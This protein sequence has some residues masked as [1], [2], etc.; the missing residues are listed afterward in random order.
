MPAASHNSNGK[1]HGHALRNA[2]LCEKSLQ[3]AQE[4]PPLAAAI[5]RIRV[6]HLHLTRL[7]L[8]R[9]SGISRGTLRDLE[10][11]VHT[12]TRRILKRFMSYCEGKGVPRERLEELHRLYAGEGDSLGELIAR[13]ELRAGSP[14]ELS[15]RV[16]ISPATLWEY[17]RGNFPLPLPLLQKLCRAVGE[18]PERAES[19][20]YEA[21][22][23]RLCERGYPEP[24]AEFW[25]LCARAGW[26]ENHLLRRGLNTATARKL[27]YLELPRWDEVEEVARRLCRDGREL[28]ALKRLWPRNTNG[29]AEHADSFGPRLKQLRKQQGITR[30]ELADLFVIGGK[31]PARIIKYVEEDGFYSAQAHPAGLAA[32]VARNPREQDQLLKDWQARRAQFQRRHRPEMRLDLRLRR[33]LFGFSLK[34]MEP[35]LGYTRTE[36]QRIERGVVPLRESAE[37]RICAAIDQAGQRRLDELLERRQQGLEQ[38]SAWKNPTS[39]DDMFQLLGRREGGLIPLARL[40][41]KAG[42]KGLWPGRLRALASGQEVPPWHL[43]K[44]VAESC[45]VDDLTQVQLDWVDRYRNQLQKPPRSPL[46]VELRLLIAETAPTLR[47]FSARLHFNYSVL[48]RDL[49]R[50][51]RDEEVRWFHIERILRAASVPADDER[52][53]DIRA[54]WYTARERSR[55]PAL[56]GKRHAPSTNGTG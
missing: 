21:E 27:R 56:H 48:V 47:A 6:E 7:E 10:L 22:R 32:L 49:Q 44:A 12:P 2:H 51:D 31:K 38:R 18:D 33:E 4:A 20:W 23:A 8:A 40:L 11:G 37:R 36:Y 35:I 25:V 3:R 26:S 54:L 50:I 41:R 53:R 45:Q 52:W 5:V 9:R 29:Q 46:G 16:G 19:I 17:R 43:V 14:R 42:L 55:K 28:A 39:L 24:L 1:L 30:R 13:L 34:D 15:R